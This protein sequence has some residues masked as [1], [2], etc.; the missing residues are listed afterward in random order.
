MK[1]T[2]NTTVVVTDKSGNL[3]RMAAWRL[4]KSIADEGRRKGVEVREDIILA[5]AVRRIKSATGWDS[6]PSDD[7]EYLRGK[8]ADLWNE[9]ISDMFDAGY[10]PKRVSG[11]KLRVNCEDRAILHERSVSFERDVLERKEQVGELRLAIVSLVTGLRRQR[12]GI[13]SG[14]LK[15][16]AALA[17][18][19][20]TEDKLAN[21]CEFL[22]DLGGVP[23]S[24]DEY[25]L[26]VAEF[27]QEKPVAPV[28]PAKEP[29]DHGAHSPSVLPPAVYAETIAER[30]VRE[31][32]AKQPAEVAA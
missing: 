21:Y 23:L 3:D 26:Y 24:I 7:Y 10:R 16:E 11:V 30:K 6:I 31:H 14:D 8:C 15:P 29:K 22:Q 1:T 13:Y 25:R 12:N 2:P 27:L 4:A 17:R 9:V 28:A 20:K 18:I 32:Q 19:A 5:K